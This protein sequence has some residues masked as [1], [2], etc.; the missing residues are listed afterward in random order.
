MRL[1]CARRSRWSEEKRRRKI[2]LRRSR[3]VAVVTLLLLCLG[4]ASAGA[5]ELVEGNMP[6]AAASSEVDALVAEALAKNPDLAAAKQEAAAARSRVSSAGALPDPMLSVT[7]ENDGTSL[8][9]GVEQMTRL[10]FMAQQ[11]FPFPG[12]LALAE[13]VASLD[14]GRG[15]TRPER[16]ALTLEGAVRRA[17]ADLLEAREDLKLVDEQVA[18]WRDI[19]EDLR[20]RYSAGLGTQQDVL[21]AQAERT[22]L[23]Q[24]RR[25]DEA[26]ERTAV[27]APE[28]ASLPARREPSADEERADSRRSPRRPLGARDRRGGA[29]AAPE[30]KDAAL[31]KER[32]KAAADL[33]RRNLKPDIVASA[34]YMN[35]GGLPLMW[36]A[37]V[38]VSVPLWA[39]KKQRP[40]I[41]EAEA[42]EE[43]A[44]ATEAS[45]RRQI[46]A[47]TEERLIR[48]EQLAAEAK[49]DAEGV[50]VQDKLSV[51]AALAELSDRL[52]SV[53]HRARGARHVL[54]RSTRGCV[55]PRRL[56]SRRGRPQRILPRPR[57][58]RRDG[59]LTRSLL[60]HRPQD[61]GKNEHEITTSH[62]S[63]PRRRFRRRPRAGRRPPYGM[64][65]EGSGDRCGEEIHVRDAPADHPRQA[66]RLPDLRHEAR[67]DRSG[68]HFDAGDTRHEVGDRDTQ[69]PPLPLAHEPCRDLT[70][71]EEGLD[72]DGLR[73]GLRG[74][75]PG[76]DG[77][78]G[79][80]RTRHDRRCRR[81]SS[82]A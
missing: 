1:F 23:L 75:G 53:R 54:H 78:P 19:E 42:L 66:R 61:V 71:A 6:S 39:G 45:L 81:G 70:R 38:G 2:F 21:R 56:H 13:K 76:R 72:G 52:G 26:A 47:R 59:V 80:P 74:R 46:E 33:A 37:G 35:R 12:K 64:H 48:V 60:R 31:A 34:A 44:S 22:R 24:Q 43:A 36:S 29:E 3:A 15:A 14:A 5:A 57:G 10:S 77:R 58:A 41:A 50:L 11:A 69:D 4:S 9:L 82:S 25:R 17:Y 67:A 65:A 62:P 8:S 55:A 16:V 40:L 73:A 20:A 49:L 18:T 32:A 51:D 30:L 63:P 79:G 27:S 68:T 7:Y 28:P